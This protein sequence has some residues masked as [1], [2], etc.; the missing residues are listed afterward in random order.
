MDFNTS[1]TS[2]RGRG[3]W[4]EERDGGGGQERRGWEKDRSGGN[5]T[6]GNAAP[7]SDGNVAPESGGKVPPESVG[8]FGMFG[9]CSRLRAASHRLMPSDARATARPRTKA[10]KKKPP[11]EAN[12]AACFDDESICEFTGLIGDSDSRR[13]KCKVDDGW[14]SV[15]V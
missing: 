4:R 14:E 6:P 13:N 11:M 3:W 10:A 5:V 1:K 9:N 15:S 7:G 2:G 12:N 8:K